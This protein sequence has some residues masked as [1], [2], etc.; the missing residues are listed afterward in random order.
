MAAALLVVACDLDRALQGMPP[1]LAPGD[2]RYFQQPE[3]TSKGWEGMLVAQVL[4]RFWVIYASNALCV[5]RL[6]PNGRISVQP[7]GETTYRQLSVP[8]WTK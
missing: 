3:D 2:R 4:P 7:K 1:P 5:A 8:N 6:T